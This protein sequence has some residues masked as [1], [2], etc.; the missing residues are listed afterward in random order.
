MRPIAA[1]SEEIDII[2]LYSLLSDRIDIDNSTGQF[3]FTPEIARACYLTS[4]D[5]MK[6]LPSQFRNRTCPTMFGETHVTKSL[7][8]EQANI[9]LDEVIT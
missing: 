2:Y 9:F 1:C 7:R 5:W 8:L 4:A 3:E 6:R